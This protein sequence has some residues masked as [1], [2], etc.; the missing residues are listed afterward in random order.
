VGNERRS[1]QEQ[2]RFLLQII[3]ATLTTYN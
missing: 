3:S 1:E 2:R